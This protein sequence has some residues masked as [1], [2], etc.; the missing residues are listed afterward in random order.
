MDSPPSYIPSVSRPVPPRAVKTEGTILETYSM[1]IPDRPGWARVGAPWGKGVPAKICEEPVGHLI[2][3]ASAI[4]VPPGLSPGLS[5]MRTMVED[6]NNHT[7]ARQNVVFAP[8]AKVTPFSY[9]K[10]NP[11]QHPP[12]PHLMRLC[13][14][15]PSNPA[16]RS[17]GG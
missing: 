11:P 16:C 15:P 10:T 1:F 5:R 13:P 2:N 8:D 9:E 7:R 3:D 17:H 6:Y 4:L 12:T 14:P